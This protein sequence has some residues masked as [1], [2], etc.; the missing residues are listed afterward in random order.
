MTEFASHR[1]TGGANTKSES[2][3]V[4]FNPACDHLA[5]LYHNEDTAW[6]W[7]LRQAEQVM[8]RYNISVKYSKPR[9]TKDEWDH[10][11]S[12]HHR[13]IEGEASLVRV[14]SP[15]ETLGIS[16]AEGQI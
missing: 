13:K 2:L 7:E 12:V 4:E 9:F 11:V 10:T 8:S 6:P 3:F 15:L 5:L 14:E 16:G 1:S